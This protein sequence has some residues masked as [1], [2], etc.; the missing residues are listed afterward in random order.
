MIN[1]ITVPT[2]TFSQGDVSDGASSPVQVLYY[3][4][5]DNNICL[6]L[7]QEEHYINFTDLQT[8]KKLVKEIEKH[9]AEAKRELDIK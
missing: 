4:G 7:L 2:F 6:E 8:L 1:L 9:E 5:F 3:R